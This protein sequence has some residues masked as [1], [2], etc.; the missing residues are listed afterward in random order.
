M[1]IRGPVGKWWP[2]VSPGKALDGAGRTIGD[3]GNRMQRMNSVSARE[4]DTSGALSGN[5]NLGF[6]QL[7]T[8]SKAIKLSMIR[9]GNED[10]PE[11]VA[12][13]PG[14]WYVIFKVTNASMTANKCVWSWTAQEVH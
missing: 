3:G 5:T 12:I 13:R 7:R 8:S 6:E 1:V 9:L 10:V 2:V 14:S 4:I 11:E